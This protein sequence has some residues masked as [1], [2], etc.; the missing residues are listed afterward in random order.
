MFDVRIIDNEAVLFDDDV[1][2]MNLESLRDYDVIRYE[3]DN[4]NYVTIGWDNTIRWYDSFGN[5]HRDEYMPDIITP[6]GYGY[7]I[8]N[9]PLEKFGP[10]VISEKYT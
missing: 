10:A 5:G 9:Y 8:R 1:Q 7:T 4:G 2:V 3:F 6:D